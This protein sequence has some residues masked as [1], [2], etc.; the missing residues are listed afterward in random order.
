[1]P[2]APS[3][4]HSST[5]LATWVTAGTT[6]AP[7]ASSIVMLVPSKSLTRTLTSMSRRKR[8]THSGRRRPCMITR[9]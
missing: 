3:R 8:S 6:P 7:M 1:M 4:T 2:L 5:P 9:P